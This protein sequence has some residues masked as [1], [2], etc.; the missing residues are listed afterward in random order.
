[1]ILSGDEITLLDI[2]LAVEGRLL[3]QNTVYAQP[4]VGQ[5]SDVR[6]RLS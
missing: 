2:V 1:M 4:R 3:L 6:K 5:A